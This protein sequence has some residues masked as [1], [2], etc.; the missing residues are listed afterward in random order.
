MS[1]LTIVPFINTK[2]E[3]RFQILSSKGN[4]FLNANGHG[5]L[6]KA[7]AYRGLVFFCI[8]KKQNKS[9]NQKLKK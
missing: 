5:Y 4:T 2:G 8:H 3:E 6:S 9:N 7:S 1:R